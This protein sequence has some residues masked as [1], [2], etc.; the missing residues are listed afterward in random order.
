MVDERS[1]DDLLQF[2]EGNKPTTKATKKTKSK[3]QQS[4]PQHPTVK[5][6]RM[7]SDD[8]NPLLSFLSGKRQTVN[9]YSM[10]M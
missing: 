6:T 5:E 10:L 7:S 1:V 2:I 8:S 4:S 3:K 9:E